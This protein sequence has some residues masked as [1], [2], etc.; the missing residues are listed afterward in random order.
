[1]WCRITTVSAWEHTAYSSMD[2][3]VIW[4]VVW[5]G[6][7]WLRRIRRLIISKTHHK[8][9]VCWSNLTPKEAITMGTTDELRR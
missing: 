6:R 5:N 8:I 3:A 1:M 4:Q 9:N 2:H 7:I